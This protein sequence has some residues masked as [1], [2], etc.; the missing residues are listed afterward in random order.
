MFQFRRFPT[1]AYLIQRALTGSSPA[2]LPHS[3][4]HGS[5][6]ICGSPWLIAA[7][8]VLHRLLMPRHPPCALLRLTF[9]PAAFAARSF[10]NYKVA[11]QELC[12]LHL[13]KFLF[14]KLQITLLLGFS[15]NCFAL[16]LFCRFASSFL[17]PF[18]Q[19]SRCKGRRMC[20]PN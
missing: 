3:E 14:V 10:V 17:S 6:P 13:Q 18:V 5:M 8:H 9:D 20:P 4:I 7:C 11:V 15:T 1:H 12:K 19:F 16:T 2:G